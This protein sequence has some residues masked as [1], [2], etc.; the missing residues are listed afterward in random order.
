M[1]D[2]AT[3]TKEQIAKYIDNSF[4]LDEAD[5]AEVYEQYIADIIKYKFGAICVLPYHIPLLVERIGDF[6]RENQVRIG[7][8]VGFPYG[9]HFSDVKLY[10]ARQ[11]VKIGATQLDMVLNASALKE[12]NYK[13]YQYECEEFAKIG[14]ECNVVTK[15]IIGVNHLTDEEIQIATRIVA[16]AGIDQ[17]KSSTGLLVGLRPDYHDVMLVKGVLEEMGP[18]CHTKMKFCTGSALEAY[19]FIQLGCE[20][21]GT[22]TG[23]EVCERLEHYQAQIRRAA[24]R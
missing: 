9:Q 7:C 17:V 6:C 12:K 14:R 4:V 10:E 24:A 13:L 5:T 16:E 11:A 20:S 23:V 19:A 15:G 3:M 21:I 1:A 8:P 22:H 18:D 2:V